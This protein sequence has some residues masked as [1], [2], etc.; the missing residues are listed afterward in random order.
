MTRQQFSKL[1]NKYLS[2]NA[3][4]EEEALLFDWY[5]RSGEG[6]IAPE[7]MPTIEE[8][9][10]LFSN[11]QQHIQHTSVRRSRVRLL[12]G[13]AA[14]L[15][16]AVS[17]AFSGY[18]FFNKH[19]LT[20]RAIPD[21]S[22]I[23]AKGEKRKINLPD[24]TLVWLNAD[25]K[26]SFPSVFGLAKREV[27]LT[28]EAYFEIAPNAHSPFVV[29]TSEVD[30]QVLGTVFNIKAYPTDKKVETSLISGAVQVSMGKG[31]PQPRLLHPGQ[32]LVLLKNLHPGK[33]AQDKC[34]IQLDS[35]VQDRQFNTARETSWRKGVLSFE[36]ERFDDLAIELERWFN[37][38][39]V[40][41]NQELKSY[42]FTGALND[43]ALP[44]VM[45]ALMLSR[46]FNYRKGEG[47]NIIVYQ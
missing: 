41:E 9:E 3:S 37:I 15:V 23:T 25:S 46:H 20:G 13:I 12:T 18:Y 43:A 31:D 26:L 33:A 1:L 30:V 4:Q 24:G 44:T 40:F 7:H 47:N 10:A 27:T 39:V 16:L 8:Q 22:M 34:S 11:I 2:G 19:R 21:Q 5:N 36:N 14:S 17:F 45:E 42:R 38:K 29:H 28:G 32:K 35:I 6:P